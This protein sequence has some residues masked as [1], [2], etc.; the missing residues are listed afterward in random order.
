MLPP[1]CLAILTESDWSALGLS[2]RVSFVAM[3]LVLPPG[4]FLGWF[5]ANRRFPGRA[6]VDALLAVPLVLP[7]VVI[8][9]LLLVALGNNA[10]IGGWLREGLG[11]QLAFTWKAAALA[12]AVMS[13]PL[14]VRAAK[15]AFESCDARLAE[16]ARSLGA[17]PWQAFWRVTL[18]LAGPG[19]SAGMVLAFA[20]GFGEFGATILF[21]GNIPGETRTLPLAIY[22]HSEMPGGES[23]ALRLVIVSLVVAITALAMAEWLRTR[24]RDKTHA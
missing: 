19:L 12:S 13:F 4:I 11:V 8:G 2:L 1:P 17:S 10:A 20:R 3:L 5:L 6:L 15:G 9:Y 18:P 24:R 21:A 23:D 22:T 16:A 14:L 7:P